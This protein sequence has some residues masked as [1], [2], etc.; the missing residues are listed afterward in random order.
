MLLSYF[1]IS[2]RKLRSHIASYLV[3]VVVLAMGYVCLLSSFFL[4]RIYGQTSATMV[5]TA[6][7]LF[8]SS[9]VNSTTSRRFCNKE[10]S[11]RKLLGADF[12]QIYTLVVAETLVMSVAA[13]L[14]SLIILDLKP[15]GNFFIFH[16]DRNASDYID[17]LFLGTSI[18]IVSL[19][20]GLFPTYKLSRGDLGSR[21]RMN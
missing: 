20:I 4:F 11:I 17:L 3:N 2:F 19:L 8:I 14:I 16:I 6:L 5:A 9:G 1:I 7:A 13:A 15:F 21:L 12:R 18:L 10:F